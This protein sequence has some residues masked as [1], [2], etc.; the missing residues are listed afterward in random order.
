MFLGLCNNL[1]VLDL[2]GNCLTQ[3]VNYRATVKDNIT[4]LVY[5]DK[6]PFD[7]DINEQFRRELLCSEYQPGNERNGA[8]RRIDMQSANNPYE[9]IQQMNYVLQ[10][11]PASSSSAL[12]THITIGLDHLKRPS[13]S[14]TTKSKYDMSVGEPVCGNIVTKARK[15]KQLLRTAWGDTASSSSSISS[16]SSFTTKNTDNSS[17]IHNNSSESL[18]ESSKLWRMNSQ[19]HRD[20]Y[21]K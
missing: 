16:D 2:T 1:K 13:T 17:A 9:S 20:R 6:V 12:V 3:K 21:K 14:D 8:V 11:R 19:E 7:I 10:S 5:L 15:P 18:L 4:Q